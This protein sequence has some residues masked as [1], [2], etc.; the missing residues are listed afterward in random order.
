MIEAFKE[1]GYKTV[2]YKGHQG[3]IVHV[4]SNPRWGEV[5]YKDEYGVTHVD[6]VHVS[7][8]EEDV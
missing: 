4:Y 2:N 8:V 7:E 1:H 3:T 5:E 6:T